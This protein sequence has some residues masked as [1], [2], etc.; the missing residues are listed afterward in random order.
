MTLFERLCARCEVWRQV[1]K[2][3]ATGGVSSMNTEPGQQQMSLRDIQ[4]AVDEAHQ[5]RM[6][7]EAHA[8]SAAGIKD[9]IRAGVNTIENASLIDDKGIALAKKHGA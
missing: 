9:A 1:I 8:H 3:C 7:V 5:S 2:N 6:Q 4:V